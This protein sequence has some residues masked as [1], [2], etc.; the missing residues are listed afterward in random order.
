MAGPVVHVALV[1][2]PNAGKTTLFNALTGLRHRV[3]NY[4]GVTVEVKS[5][6]REAAGFAAEIVDLP[7]TYSLA[8]RSPDEVLTLELLLGL[9]PE[10]PRPAVAIAVVD[11]SNLERNL[12]LATQLL[13]VG[14][15]VVI[16]LNMI[17]R[18]DARGE[19]L[20]CPGLAARLGVPVVAVQANA[21]RGLD[22]LWRAVAGAA[23]GPAPPH[24][25]AF[26]EP[27]AVAAAALAEKL[28]AP[29][30]L[31]QRL[32][33]DAGGG[34]LDHLSAQRFGAAG[35]AEVAAARAGL[36][37]AGQRSPALEAR[38]R[39]AWIAA[40]TAGLHHRSATPPAGWT[41]RLDR[42]A[43]HPVLGLAVLFATMATVFA[44]LFFLGNAL[45]GQVKGVLAAL[46][47]V[48]VATLPP[49]PLRDLLVN[50][51]LAGVAAVLAFVPQIA[52]LFGFLAML[53]DSGYLARAAFLMDRILARFGL[54][55]KSFLPMLSS[56][57]CA[58]PGV[59]ATRVIEDRR[60]RL[61]TILVAPLMSCSA[62]L[63]VYV[64]LINAFIPG[65]WRQTLT[66]LAMYFVGVVAAPFVAWALKRTVLR[67][68]TPSFL[69]ELPPYRWPSWRN[70]LRRMLENAWSF[71]RR[72]GTLILATAVVVWGLSYYPRPPGIAAAFA[73]EQA[74][75]AEDS[76]QAKA[77]ERRVAK[78]YL[79][80]SWLARAGKAIEPAVRPLGWD[81]KIA[82]ATIA[83]FPARE[84][85]LG[86][87]GTLHSVEYDDSVEGQNRM[88]E[89]MKKDAWPDG[90]PI[91]TV[92]TALSIMVFFALCCQ[93]AGTLAA[94]RRE[95][96]S[97][98]WPALT[99][100][101]MTVLAYL[102]ALATFQIASRF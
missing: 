54:S 89:A 41:D 99:F 44:G 68:E 65:W 49:G 34:A 15:P 62:R 36:E 42:V 6:R 13:D 10:A 32:L 9:R 75:V 45:G 55:G 88:A 79:D 3:G 21:G 97:W 76:P 70:A 43:L 14:V 22:E 48:L 96:H 92:A 63:P 2:N 77:L 59:M 31:A 67:G 40:A 28:P 100:A 19:R 61:A 18:C 35:T 52:M 26:P 56:F 29:A 102:A 30:F 98:R 17:D 7:G 1:G 101:Y 94:I 60:D 8:P 95:T 87:M 85:V 4:P 83:A 25:A 27:F 82:V 80:Q 38:V 11:A 73:A 37:A 90:R 84:V 39:Y 74:A 16:A 12:Y 53:E 5:G 64:L 58:I 46:G 24:R 47:D 51:A 69:L 86:V 66:L 50:G 81:W 23:G 78:A 91:Y 72:A 57:A 93:C 20:D 71:I 33:L